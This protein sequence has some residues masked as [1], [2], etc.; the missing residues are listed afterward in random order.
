MLAALEK[1]LIFRLLVLFLSLWFAAFVVYTLI[2]GF[3][4]PITKALSIPPGGHVALIANPTGGSSQSYLIQA[5]GAEITTPL[6]LDG[7]IYAG[8]RSLTFRDL[9]DPV[10]QVIFTKKEAG[11]ATIGSVSKTLIVEVFPAGV[12][13]SDIP[14]RPNL[15]QQ[16]FFDR[17]LY[18]TPEELPSSSGSRVIETRAVSCQDPATLGPLSIYALQKRAVT[19]GI[20]TRVWYYAAEQKEILTQN[21]REEATVLLDHIVL[22]PFQS[23]PVVTPYI[24]T[25]ETPT[26]HTH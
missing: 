15:Y 23:A 1:Y 17:C 9:P 24:R 20:V 11:H 21:Y 3:T 22:S 4:D 13:T 26:T 14:A 8:E 18:T 19:Q 25:D 5:N 12:R 7:W 10:V 16:S 6:P 2:Y